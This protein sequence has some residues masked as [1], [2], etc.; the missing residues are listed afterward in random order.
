MGGLLVFDVGFI[1]NESCLTLS[2]S[3]H[4]RSTKCFKFE[5]VEHMAW[6]RVFLFVCF[7]EKSK[8]K[9]GEINTGMLPEIRMTKISLF[10][11]FKFVQG[12]H[13]VRNRPNQTNCLGHRNLC[14]KPSWLLTASWHF[15]KWALQRWCGSCPLSGELGKWRVFPRPLRW[16]FL[17]R[18]GVVFSFL[19]LFSPI[20]FKDFCAKKHFFKN[21]VFLKR[22]S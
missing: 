5:S 20:E 22:T 11:F 12:R 15:S 13:G 18:W 9:V 4:A 14:C 19:E 16:V 3:C 8:C 10:F 2:I 21:I 17:F 7:C 6:L 1:F